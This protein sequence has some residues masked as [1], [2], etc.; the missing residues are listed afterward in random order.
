MAKPNRKL[1]QRRPLRDRLPPLHRV[2]AWLRRG[3]RVG[4]PSL[5]ALA[6]L[7]SVLGVAL[8][9]WTWMHASPRFALR[10]I[11]VSGHARLSADD[12]ARRAGAALGQ[13]LFSIRPG[14]VEGR[15]RADPWI[16]AAEARRAL[17]DRLLLQV[18][19]RRPAGLVLVDGALYLADEHGTPFKRASAAEQDGLVVVSGVP[20]RLWTEQP[21]A[22]VALV[23]RALALHADWRGGTDR[24]AIG[25]INLSRHGVTLYT[26]ERAAAV[27]LGPPDEGARAA[28]GRFDAVWQALSD[29]ERAAARTIHLDS[30]TRP[31]RVAVSL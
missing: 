8:G 5:L 29:E 2:G 9:A 30:R 22:A 14:A 15:L 26:L 7:A 21:A 20:R 1:R 4:A 11:E 13:N 27:E 18:V 10:K 28:M 31:N 23:G 3:L 19:E 17:P 24:P 16:A 25:E 6:A 12:I